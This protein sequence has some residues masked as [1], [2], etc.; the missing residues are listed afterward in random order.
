MVLYIKGWQVVT[1]ALVTFLRKDNFSD[2]TSPLLC[3]LDTVE[4]G[5]WTS[6][7]CA[8]S[9]SLSGWHRIDRGR[10]EEYHLQ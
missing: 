7:P 9:W 5:R 6:C 3:V 8:F 4:V 10:K 2:T 1:R